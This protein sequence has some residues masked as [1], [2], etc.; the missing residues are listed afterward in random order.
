MKITETSGNSQNG[1][2]G[3]RV[4]IYAE[5]ENRVFLIDRFSVPSMYGA[6]RYIAKHNGIYRKRYEDAIAIAGY[7]EQGKVHYSE[8]DEVNPNTL[9]SQ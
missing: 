2:R 3:Q 1:I 7:V 5:V 4:S 6:K 8:F 9:R